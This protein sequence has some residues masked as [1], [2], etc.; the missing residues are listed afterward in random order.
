L[1]AGA[2]LADFALAAGFLA[3]G[4]L[5]AGFFVVFAVLF[6]A[7]FI[8]TPFENIITYNFWI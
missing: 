6:V 1:A 5:A 8:Y 2:F 3:A 4:F 7:F